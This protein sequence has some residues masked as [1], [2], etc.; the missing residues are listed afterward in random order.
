MNKRPLN[1]DAH[2][3]SALMR[4]NI[5]PDE[6]KKDEK[7]YSA[8]LSGSANLFRKLYTIQTIYQ[9]STRV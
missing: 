7:K 3:N 8:I 1:I 6:I 4:T 5:D 9:A 2:C